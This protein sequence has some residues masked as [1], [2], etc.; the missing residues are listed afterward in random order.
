MLHENEPG[1]WEFA[2]ELEAG[3]VPV[4]AIP[5]HADVDPATFGRVLAYLVDAPADDPAH[6]PRPRRRVR[7]DRRHARERAGAALDEARLQRV[8]RGAALRARRP[9][10]RRARAPADR[11][12]ARPRPLPL[13]DRGLPGAGLRDRPLRHRRRPRAGAV[14]GRRA[15]LPL[16]RPPDPDQGARRAAARVQEGARGAARRAARHRRPRRPRARAEGPLAR[17]R[18]A[19]RRC[20]SSATSRRS[21]ARSSSRRSSSCRRSARASAWSRSRRWSARG[22]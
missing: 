14:R 15:A 22:P 18:A 8:P 7:P 11:D 13:R 3:G 19:R 20:A 9:H 6:A 21:S 1:A 17:A 5:M 2:R 16:H 12:L 10:D 4:D